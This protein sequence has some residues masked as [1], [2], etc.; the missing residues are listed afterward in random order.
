MR[1]RILTALALVTVLSAS[2]TLVPARRPDAWKPPT[3]LFAAEE[4]MRDL[5][6]DGLPFRSSTAGPRSRCPSYVVKLKE[7]EREAR[8]VVGPSDLRNL[9][10]R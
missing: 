2:L 9:T 3:H 1:N 7:D 5:L 6:D 8:I 4:A 10:W